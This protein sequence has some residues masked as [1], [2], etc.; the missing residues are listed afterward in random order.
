VRLR[1][2]LCAKGGRAQN[3]VRAARRPRPLLRTPLSALCQKRTSAAQSII[4]SARLKSLA[5]WIGRWSWHPLQT[6]KQPKPSARGGDLRPPVWLGS[7]RAPFSPL[8]LLLPCFRKIPAS[9]RL[10][11]TCRHNKFPTATAF[12]ESLAAL[13]RTNSQLGQIVR[14]YIIRW[15]SAPQISNQPPGGVRSGDL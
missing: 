5:A 13:R 12:A 10:A 7:S 8:W 4:S 2:P 14:S 1:C 11:P 9:V 6:L 3:A 15:Q